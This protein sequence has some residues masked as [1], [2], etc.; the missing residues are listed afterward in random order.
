MWNQ[1]ILSSLIWIHTIYREGFKTY[2]QTTKA[3]D[4]GRIGTTGI[5]K[6]ECQFIHKL[7]ACW[8][9]QRINQ[10]K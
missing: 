2:Q 5:D 3:D 6:C 9:E 7:Q 4:F 1:I 10:S 8:L